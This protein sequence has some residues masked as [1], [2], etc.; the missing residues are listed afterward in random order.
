[1]S[2]DGDASTQLDGRTKELDKQAFTE[3]VSA[4]VELNAR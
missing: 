4:A 1:M 2:K 3:L